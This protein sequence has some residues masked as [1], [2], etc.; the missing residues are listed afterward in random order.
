MAKER[1]NTCYV[2]WRR[3]GRDRGFDLVAKLTEKDIEAEILRR[4]RR[5]RG[6]DPDI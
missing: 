5:E 2:Y 1:C 3:N 4:Q 6:W